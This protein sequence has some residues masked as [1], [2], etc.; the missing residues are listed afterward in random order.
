MIALLLVLVICCVCLVVGNNKIE[1][2]KTKWE[3]QEKVSLEKLQ[4]HINFIKKALPQLSDF[5]TRQCFLDF[6]HEILQEGL[7]NKTIEPEFSQVVIKAVGGGSCTN[8][9]TAV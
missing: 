3:T 7:K 6:L 2:E 9:T 5:E 1:E 8:H 4:S